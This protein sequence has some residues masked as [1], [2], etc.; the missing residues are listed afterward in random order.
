MDESRLD[1]IV[2]KEHLKERGFRQ[3]HKIMFRIIHDQEIRFIEVIQNGY[4]FD[5]VYYLPK[6]QREKYEE[7]M[8]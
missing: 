4:L 7:R 8:E 6:R 3:Y 2:S 1:D 5:G